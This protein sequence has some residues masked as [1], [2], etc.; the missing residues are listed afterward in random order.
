MCRQWCDRLLQQF[1]TD[2]AHKDCVLVAEDGTKIEAHQ[3]LLASMSPMFGDALSH[4]EGGGVEEEVTILI[5]ADGEVL[6]ELITWMYF[7]AFPKRRSEEVSTLAKFLKVCGADEMIV[8]QD[9]AQKVVTDSVFVEE[10][11]T[12]F[13]YVEDSAN[14]CQAETNPDSGVL[15][16]EE[17]GRKF[18]L[19]EE[20]IGSAVLY[21]EERSEKEECTIIETTQLEVEASPEIIAEPG[22]HEV[23]QHP[24]NEASAH[25]LTTTG[26]KISCPSCGKMLSLRHYTKHHRAACSGELVHSC[27]LCGRKGFA[28]QATLQDH[29]RARHTKEK[30]FTCGICG[31]SFPA[32]SHLAHHRVKKHSVNSKGE[33][34]PRITFPCSQCGKVL[35][36]KPKL[37]AHIRVIHQGIKDFSCQLCHKNFSSK[38]NLEI[39]IGI[40]HTGVLPYR[41]QNCDKSFTRKRLLTQHW[42]LEHQLS[43]SLNPRPVLVV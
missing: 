12:T 4:H 39:H 25:S 21:V 14:K 11:C 22:Q 42:A 24:M 37:Q 38:S 13:L 26:S 34:Q 30:P 28:T 27:T 10:S 7:G 31:K 29:I 23:V 33:K 18:D 35:T 20:E 5:P 43:E 3:V 32:T 8:K 36:T 1:Q 16:V 40:A 15:F 2:V 6:Q 17:D 19:Q 41:C 9:V